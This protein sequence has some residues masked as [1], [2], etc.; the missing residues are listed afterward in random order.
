MS[1]IYEPIVD[2]ATDTEIKQIITRSERR[3]AME[4][5]IEGKLKVTHATMSNIY[6]PTVDAV[7]DT[8][9]EPEIVAYSNAVF[10]GGVPVPFSEYKTKS[11]PKLV[12]PTRPPPT[13]TRCT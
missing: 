2:A 8:K 3:L 1:N 7:M 10:Y 5:K 12:E 9:I 4:T 6:E 11:S 13:P